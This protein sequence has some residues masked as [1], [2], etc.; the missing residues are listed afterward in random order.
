MCVWYHRSMTRWSR[1]MLS[2]C[3]E[4]STWALQRIHRWG[5]HVVA[6]SN[7][8]MWSVCL[9]VIIH[10]SLQKFINDWLA[11]QSRDLKVCVVASFPR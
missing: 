4:N 6:T 11:S 3:R 2:N 1:S 9:T 8:T 10:S 5:L 7:D